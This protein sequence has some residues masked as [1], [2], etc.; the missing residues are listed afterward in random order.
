MGAEASEIL[1]SNTPLL[2]G[3]RFLAGSF[4][5]SGKKGG[6]NSRNETQKDQI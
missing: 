6:V 3:P 1:L 4:S 5:S 2:A